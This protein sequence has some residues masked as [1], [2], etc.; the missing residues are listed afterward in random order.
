VLVASK[1]GSG[2]AFYLCVPA[3]AV[4]TA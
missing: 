2:S 4:V 3:G 1:P